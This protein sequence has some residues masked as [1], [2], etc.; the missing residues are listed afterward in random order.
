MEELE[1]TVT[2]AAVE[3][4]SDIVFHR[5]SVHEE[6]FESVRPEVYRGREYYQFNSHSRLVVWYVLLGALG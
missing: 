6:R 3:A 4:C 1:A 5:A 2:D